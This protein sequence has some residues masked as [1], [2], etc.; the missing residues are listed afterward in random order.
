MG[1]TPA[2]SRMRTSLMWRASHGF[3][4]AP[5]ATQLGDLAFDFHSSSTSHGRRATSPFTRSHSPM[6]FVHI[7]PLRSSFLDLP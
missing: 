5:A 7:Q 1:C 2:G 6:Q 3:I 4:S